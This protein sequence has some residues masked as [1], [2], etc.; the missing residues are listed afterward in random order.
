[1]KRMDGWR[2]EKLCQKYE[3]RLLTRQIRMWDVPESLRRNPACAR[4]IYITGFRAARMVS[5]ARYEEDLVK[6]EVEISLVE[7]KDNHPVL[8]EQLRTILA[9]MQY[10][11]KLFDLYEIS[12]FH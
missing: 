4:S 5:K 3:L 9:D 6:L 10:R 2:E 12:D 8:L 11:L 1:M 7:A